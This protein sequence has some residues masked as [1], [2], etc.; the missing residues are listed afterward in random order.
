MYHRMRAR[1]LLGICLADISLSLRIT[2]AS[3]SQPHYPSENRGRLG[4]TIWRRSPFTLLYGVRWGVRVYDTHLHAVSDHIT[5]VP[6]C[7]CIVLLLFG[8]LEQSFRLFILRAIPFRGNLPAYW[9]R[10]DVLFVLFSRNF[11][12]PPLSTEVSAAWCL[13]I[14]LSI[15]TALYFRIFLTWFKDFFLSFSY[16]AATA[17]WLV[18]MAGLE[19]AVFRLC[20]GYIVW[21]PLCLLLSP[22]VYYHCYIREHS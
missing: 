11:H 1:G 14:L 18:L 20:L 10:R 7:C 4:P 22:P 5:D 16:F 19:V 17:F 9:F 15:K 21:Y 2:K 3:L 8:F 13:A 6:C 12:I